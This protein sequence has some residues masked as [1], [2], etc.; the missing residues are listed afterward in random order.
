M[1]RSEESSR[2]WADVP[3][4][5]DKYEVSLHGVVKRKGGGIMK[6]TLKSSEMYHRVRLTDIYRGKRTMAYVHRLVAM[7]FIPNPKRLPV[8]NHIDSNVENNSVSNLEWCTQG[9]NIRHAASKGRIK[10]CWKGG[11]G[12]TARFNEEE[13][14]EIFSAVVYKGIPRSKVAAKFSVDR[15][16]IDRIV[17]R[18]SYRYISIPPDSETLSQSTP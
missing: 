2:I 11:R 12:P 9:H 13:I 10:C 16:C 3:G 8:V 4:W 5:E 7:T 15:H 1:S 17:N 18:K 14:I 6:H